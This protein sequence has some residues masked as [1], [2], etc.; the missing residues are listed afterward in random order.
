[1]E[2]VSSLD[3]PPGYFAQLVW[4][5]DNH[6]DIFFKDKIQFTHKLFWW[7]TVFIN[8]ADYCKCLFSTQY[9]LK[10]GKNDLG[11]IRYVTNYNTN[12]CQRTQRFTTRVI[13]TAVASIYKAT[14]WFRPGINW[15]KKLCSFV[16]NSCSNPLTPPSCHPILTR[17]RFA[18][19]CHGRMHE[20]PFM[21]IPL[22]VHSSLSC[23]QDQ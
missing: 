11:R 23:F 9:L 20:P 8:S 19:P 5:D 18:R 10:I 21:L 14:A 16:A 15:Q 2:P 6:I 3:P 13:T 12:N 4:L 22:V 7:V 1:M 17:T